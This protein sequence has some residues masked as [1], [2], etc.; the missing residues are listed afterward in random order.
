MATLRALCLSLSLLIAKSAYGYDFS[1]VHII[2]S[3]SVKVID[4]HYNALMS[5]L[6]GKKGEVKILKRNTFNAQNSTLNIK[7]YL[8]SLKKKPKLLISMATL[9]SK[10]LAAYAKEHKIPLLFVTVS[11]P[12]EA[13]LIKEF[14]KPTGSLITG[15]SHTIPISA[16]VGYLNEM[17]RVEKKKGPIRFGYVHSSYPSEVGF[18]DRLLKEFAASHE[19]SLISKEITYRPKDKKS[20]KAD[21]FTAASSIDNQIDFFIMPIG[22]LSL[23]DGFTKGLK[24][25][26]KKAILFC[27]HQ[28]SLEEGAL[29][30]I[31]SNTKEVGRL[32]S[33]MLLSFLDGKKI[34]QIAPRRVASVKL[35]LNLKVAKERG[36]IVPSHILRLSVDYLIK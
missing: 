5:H 32:A 6:D 35:G 23:F 18:R 36:F 29:F 33:Q 25:R 12:I 17:A 9:A 11:Q 21:F 13:G 27:S 1:D 2:K 19:M 30:L 22:P 14:D 7:N 31:D 3:M 24:E 4:D 15:V 10:Y 16:I 26:T 20:M 28:K 34:G 8:A